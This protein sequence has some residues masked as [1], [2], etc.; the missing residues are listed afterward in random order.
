M[1]GMV[2]RTILG[3]DGVGIVHEVGARFG[4]FAPA[5]AS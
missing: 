1:S 5:T 4:T 2:E 3:H